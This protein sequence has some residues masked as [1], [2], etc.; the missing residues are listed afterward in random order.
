MPTLTNSGNRS[1]GLGFF[2]SDSLEVEH[3][4]DQLNRLAVV[5]LEMLVKT[6]SPTMFAR[7][8]HRFR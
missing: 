5:A 3:V 2:R 1:L 8:R 7:S 6:A 4:A